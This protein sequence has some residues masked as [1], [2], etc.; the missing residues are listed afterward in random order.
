MAL[1]KFDINGTIYEYDWEHI[2]VRDAMQL[3]SATGLN[4]RPF[5]VGLN[6]LDPDCL[7][8]LGW[9]L[10]TRA[11]VK[12]ADGQPIQLKDVDFDT[13]AFFVEEDEPEPVDPTPGE[14]S[15]S[16]LASTSPE[17]STTTP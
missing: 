6:E 11:G 15:T 9:L 1:S 16:P 2:S 10:Q 8:A 3:K 17:P 12:G 5:S 7:V 4:L 14:P 13:N